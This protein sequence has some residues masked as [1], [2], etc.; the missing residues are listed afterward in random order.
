MRSLNQRFQS[1]KQGLIATVSIFLGLIVLA[2]TVKVTTETVSMKLVSTVMGLLPGDTAETV[3]IIKLTEISMAMTEMVSI[4]TVTTDMVSMKMVLTRVDMVGMV[5]ITKRTGIRTVLT[6]KVSMGSK[7]MHQ[8]M[9]E[10][11][12][13]SPVYPR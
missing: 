5:S 8:L 11:A 6:G 4:L 10:S 13:A 12:S 2:S 7:L 3:S 9:P 1:L